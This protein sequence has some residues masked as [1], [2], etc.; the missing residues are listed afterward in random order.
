MNSTHEAPA[1]DASGAR[2]LPPECVDF[3]PFE[4]SCDHLSGQ[5][6]DDPG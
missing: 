6:V 3:Q 4:M 2:F 1:P 5:S